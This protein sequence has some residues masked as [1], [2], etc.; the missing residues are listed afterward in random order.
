MEKSV[1]LG[2]TKGGEGR[3]DRSMQEDDKASVESRGPISTQNCKESQ[4]L[5]GKFDELRK[6]V[7]EN[8]DIIV[9]S[10]KELVEIRQEVATMKDSN[11]FQLVKGKKAAK[12]VTEKRDKG[13]MVSNRFKVLSEEE[14]Y[15]IGDSLVREQT[16]NF[17]KRNR[18]RRK[19][20]SF[21]GCKAKKVVEEVSKLELQSKDSCIIAHAGS[22]DLFL[23]NNKVGNSEPLVQDLKTLVD[24]VAEKTNRGIIVGMLPRSFASYHASSKA[25]GINE[26]I[27]KYCSQ[28]EVRFLDLW[29]VFVGK[30]LYF[31]KDGIHLNEA[32]HRKL[33]EILSHECETLLA[34][35]A[36]VPT[37]DQPHSKVQDMSENEYSFEGFSEGN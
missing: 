35:N 11:E 33:G 19:V 15:V 8:R 26:R 24:T 36:K 23:R 1:D 28:K 17:A 14:T 9:E 30:R 21:P 31:R 4:K 32:G 16:D 2:R 37:A 12:S 6:V 25:I 5:E 22:N 3:E 34:S 27:E 7:L 18:Q 13:I 10:G 29:K 20:K